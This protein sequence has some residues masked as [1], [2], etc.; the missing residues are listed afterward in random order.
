MSQR[1]ATTPW[2]ETAKATYR[3]IINFHERTNRGGFRTTPSGVVKLGVAV[4]IGE[5]LFLT[6]LHVLQWI[7]GTP[8]AQV[9]HTTHKARIWLFSGS[10]N[11]DN[12][13]VITPNR[14]V[15]GSLEVEAIGW[16][17]SALGRALMNSQAIYGGLMDRRFETDIRDDFCLLEAIERRWKATLRSGSRPHVLSGN[18]LGPPTPLTL[19]VTWVGINGPTEEQVKY[20]PA[21]NSRRHLKDALKALNPGIIT[22]VTTTQAVRS[23]CPAHTIALP[24]VNPDIIRY[25]IS[26]S[27][28]SSGTGIYESTSKRLIGLHCLHELD[29]TNQLAPDVTDISITSPENMGCAVLLTS[30]RFRDFVREIV[31]PNF[32]RIGTLRAQRLAN[33]W[34]RMVVNAPYI[35]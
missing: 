12:K 9:T 6:N 20:D 25:P 14:L 26:T 21:V 13:S 2:I 10:G 15:K 30:Q 4:H 35:A 34:G 1:L 16:P 28:G 23:V 31:I 19:T 8:V 22:Y 5:G 33:N 29:H 18:V 7:P 11:L 3:V 24:G 27:G 17:S 32:L